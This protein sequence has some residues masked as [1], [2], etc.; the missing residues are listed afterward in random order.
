MGIDP[1]SSR[2]GWEGFSG[3]GSKRRETHPR[4]PAQIFV[5]VLHHRITRLFL[6]SKDTSTHLDQRGTTKK[7]VRTSISSCG[8]GW[9]ST[10]G[11]IV[12][13]E[14][15][16]ETKETTGHNDHACV[17]CTHDNQPSYTMVECPRS[18]RQKGHEKVA[19]ERRSLPRHEPKGRSDESTSRKKEKKTTSRPTICR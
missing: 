4:S 15:Q 17:A 7:R 11:S 18:Q 6:P 1:G 12:D 8:R 9:T 19:S 14:N 16:V 10:R 3:L 13:D 5:F 2:R